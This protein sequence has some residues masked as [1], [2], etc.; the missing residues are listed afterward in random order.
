M[1]PIIQKFQITSFIKHHSVGIFL[2]F[3]KFPI[4]GVAKGGRAGAPP[5]LETSFAPAG[6]FPNMHF[7]HDVLEFV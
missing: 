3:S 2:F 1:L 7:F 5:P 4:N 6:K